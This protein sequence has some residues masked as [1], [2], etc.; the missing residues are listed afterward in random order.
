MKPL[1][2][3]SQDT[4]DRGQRLTAL[5]NAINALRLSP[6]P[7]VPPGVKVDAG[8]ERAINIWGALHEL[9]QRETEQFAKEMDDHN[10]AM[11]DWSD[12]ILK[13]HDI[14]HP[15]PVPKQGI[16]APMPKTSLI[17]SRVDSD[18]EA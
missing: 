9:H 14:P 17:P 8:L 18:G 16:P 5:L 7:P 13:Q 11:R 10:N 2:V 6:Q 12:T 4:I 15:L 1:P 3:L